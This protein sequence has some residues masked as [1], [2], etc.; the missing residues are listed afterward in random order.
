[1]RQTV[2]ACAVLL[3]WVTSG[4]Q[5]QWLET[6]IGLPDS[7][8]G[9]YPVNCLVHNP[10]DNRV[11]AAGGGGWMIVLDAVTGAK[12]GRFAVPRDVEAMCVNPLSSR[13]Y[14]ATRDTIFAVDCATGSV[15]MRIAVYGY[16]PAIA[17]YPE[18][19]RVY[20]VDA[21]SDDV[22]VIDC[23]PD[24][25]LARIATGE[26]AQ[27]FAVCPAHSKVYCGLRYADTS[28]VVIDARGDSLLGSIA[29]YGANVAELL[30]DPVSDRLFCPDYPW[31]ALAV[32]DCARDSVVRY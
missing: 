20:A 24:T 10:A 16:R 9:L 2:L 26:P 13:L 17:C 22:L 25:V 6:T 29:M 1:M 21:D 5:A 8:S 7:L 11:Y 27:S 4:A 28:V 30:Y 18:A 32:V 15:T 14:A 12:L 31:G 19:G 3:V 23:G